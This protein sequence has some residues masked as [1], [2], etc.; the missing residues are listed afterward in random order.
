MKSF[1]LACVLAVA[2][3]AWCGCNRKP[4]VVTYKLAQAPPAAPAQDADE[5]AGHDHGDMP[6]NHP[7]MAK[8]APAG[9]SLPKDHP[10]IGGAATAAGGMPA[11]GALPK[12]M[13]PDMATAP[14]YAWDAPA[15]W[16]AKPAS[17]M[18]IA[19]FTVP[20]AAAGQEGD[21][22]LIRLG[23]EAGGLV[24]NVNRWRGQVNLPNASDAEIQA[25]V[26]QV[27]TQLGVNAAVVECAGQE[28]SILA[29][30]IAHQGGTLFVKL[31]GPPATITTARAAFN[32]IVAS[33]RVN[34][35][36]AAPAP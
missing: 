7:P 14:A 1:L 27:P 20:G 19:S 30:I 17:S 21:F 29:A 13:M 34:A 23:G 10:P 8:A 9:A 11:M 5:H 36:P 35:A 26:Q 12:D 25:A 18:R 33:L 24:S 32:Q 6:A 2:A 3:G 16:T 22:S 31:T 28:T 4:E 15:A